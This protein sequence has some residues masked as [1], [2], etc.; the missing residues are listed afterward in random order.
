MDWSVN[1]LPAGSDERDYSLFIDDS[2]CDH[3]TA[4]T[5]KCAAQRKIKKPDKKW[6][7][8]TTRQIKVY[9]RILVYMRLIDLLEIHG[10]FLD[11]FCILYNTIQFAL[12]L[13]KQ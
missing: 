2:F 9:I 1:I 8:I 7:D 10:Y 6:E 4:E 12:L 3:I 13:G 11:D 5:N